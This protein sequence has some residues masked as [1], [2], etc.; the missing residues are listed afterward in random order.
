MLHRFK[1]LSK[2]KAVLQVPKWSFGWICVLYTPFLCHSSL[3]FLPCFLR[4]LLG[5]SKCSMDESGVYS[6]C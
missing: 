4:H 6:N 1:L 3:S 5:L 2:M